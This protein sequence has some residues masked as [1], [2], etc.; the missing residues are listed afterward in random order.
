MEIIL[1]FLS[2][3]KCLSSHPHHICSNSKSELRNIC[4][5]FLFV[6][7]FS[8]KEIKFKL[9]EI[10][11]YCWFMKVKYPKCRYSGTLEDVVQKIYYEMDLLLFAEED[12]E[13][14]SLL[15]SEDSNKSFNGKAY[16]DVV[17]ENDVSGRLQRIVDDHDKKLIEAKEK[18]ERALRFSSFKSS[19]P[20]LR[21]VRAPTRKSVKPK[22]DLQR[23]QKRKERE[24]AN[25]GTVCETP[26]TVNKHSNSRA[27]GSDDDRGWA[28]GR[29]PCGSV[30]KALFKDDL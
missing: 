22:T 25:Y 9:H 4:Y 14:D 13:P 29:K 11:K 30:S 16:R 20:V 26:M 1:P 7:L 27:R 10:L 12:E 6:Y 18:R 5:E 28:D 23:V 8:W 15:N 21:R 17:F 19:M 24:K 2:F 3:C